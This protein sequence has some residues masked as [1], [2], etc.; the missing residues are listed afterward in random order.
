[1]TPQE[2][3]DA[4]DAALADA[5]TPARLV[6]PLAGSTVFAID[7]TIT[8]RGYDQ[9]EIV[10]GSAISQQDRRF[11]LSPTPL[12]AGGWPGSGPARASNPLVPRNGDRIQA[13]GASSTIQEASGVYLQGELVRID[14]R[15]RGDA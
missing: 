5:G 12:V 2:T 3:I 4:L 8:L 14:G 1:V 10:S 11:V 13:N 6:R 15:T 7:C 9:T